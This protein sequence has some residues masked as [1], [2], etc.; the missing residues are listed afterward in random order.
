MKRCIALLLIP[1]L[2]AC[3]KSSGPTATPSAFTIT[4]ISINDQNAAS[5]LYN[6]NLTPVIKIYF[7]SPV[8]STSIATNITLSPA[9]GTSLSISTSLSNNDSTL[10]IQ[11]L[12]TLLPL[13]RYTIGISSLLKSKQNVI[14]G[15]T[16]VVT[17]LTQIDST[18][19]FPTLTDNVL[20]DSVQR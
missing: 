13:S 5:T 6:I 7:S 16:K 10:Q 18:D 11:P 12:S 20:L 3:N 14:F 9:S 2:F 19:K 1:I 8:D 4:S 15:T 17:F